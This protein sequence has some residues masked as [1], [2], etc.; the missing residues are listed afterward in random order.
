[1][2]IIIHCSELCRVVTN[3]I[4]LKRILFRYKR[5]FCHMDFRT[6]TIGKF[7]HCL[8]YNFTVFNICTTVVV[9]LILKGYD[10]NKFYGDIS[11]I[12]KR[13]SQAIWI[14]NLCSILCLIIEGIDT[15]I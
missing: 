10:E 4:W 12:L 5:T 11:V 14:K 8:S 9:L 15:N 6:R 2:K 1:M 3:F 13:Y 7:Y